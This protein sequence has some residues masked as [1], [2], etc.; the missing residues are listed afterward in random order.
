M[1]C[2][3]DGIGPQPEQAAISHWH[4]L[5]LLR[6]CSGRGHTILHW[7]LCTIVFC[8]I[9][10]RH[11]G[12]RSMPLA[13]HFATWILCTHATELSVARPGHFGQVITIVACPSSNVVACPS[14]NVPM[15]CLCN[16]SPPARGTP[17]LGIGPQAMPPAGQAA[18]QLN[19][20][21]RPPRCAHT[22]CLLR[23]CCSPP[24]AMRCV[25]A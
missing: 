6:A 3:V 15:G 8:F 5:V 14:G 17:T 19:F 23:P 20:S 12:T 7:Q 16:P 11:T 22:S 4:G 21:R 18:Q 25:P 24:R 1:F 2:P 9:P 13:L 10:S